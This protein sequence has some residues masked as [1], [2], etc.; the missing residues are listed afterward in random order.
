MLTCDAMDLTLTDARI[1]TMAAPGYGA[2]DDGAIVIESGRI[3]WV[4]PQAE[5]PA[6]KNTATRSV[7]GRWITPA[8]IDCHTHITQQFEDYYGDTFRKSPIDLAVGAYGDDDFYYSR[9]IRRLSWP[10]RSPAQTQ[11][12]ASWRWRIVSLRLACVPSAAG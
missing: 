4:G 1:A 6:G 3:A 12:P 11:L 7:E 9:R 10:R 5:L 2:I 8:L